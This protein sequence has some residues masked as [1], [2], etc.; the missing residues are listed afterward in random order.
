MSEIYTK[1]IGTG[2]YIPLHEKKNEDFHEYDENGRKN[3]NYQKF[4]DPTGTPLEKTDKETVTDFHTI[5]GIKS[6]RYVDPGWVTSNIGYLAAIDVYASS[7]ANPEDTD[8][9]IFAH[10]FGDITCKED[11]ADMVPAHA[12]RIK[13]VMEIIN[14]YV[15]AYDII[16]GSNTWQKDLQKLKENLSLGNKDLVV[17]VDG[18]DLAQTM[19]NAKSEF[20]KLDV[21]KEY[22]NSIVVIHNLHE[23]SC[24][25]NKVKKNMEI[26]NPEILT[27]DIL[28]GCPGWLQG[29]II[30]DRMITQ[31]HAKR[32]MVIGAETLSLVSDPRD[33]D[34][35]IYADGGGATLYEA[36]MSEKPIGIL[37]H[38]TRSDTLK[39]A[40]LLRMGPSNDPNYDRED[41]F[42]KMDGADVYEYAL[43]EVPPLVKACLDKAGIPFESVAK[44]FIHQ[45]N[46]KM[47][48][49]IL[50]RVFGLYGKKKKDIPDGIM[51]MTI[52]W[53][54]NSSIATIP[55][56]FDLVVK[57]ELD[58]HSLKSGDII[59]I[60]SIGAGMHINVMIYKMP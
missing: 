51:P 52:S 48:D 53:L 32:V 44:L 23:R 45:A 47:D 59:I 46:A 49:K 50:Q 28:F 8:C 40:Y 7:G 29:S 15:V 55:T 25:A 20:L 39:H 17:E 3:P 2:R 22:L 37:A 33:R 41:I 6:R 35:M 18:F 57:G 4:L 27:F 21:E 5:T 54:G 30:A 16:I 36:V 9:I 13:H 11:K 43:S 34:S 26:K 12:A 38:M 56:L 60:A 14:P 58:G 42:L 1:I 19:E 31:G 10:N 24:L